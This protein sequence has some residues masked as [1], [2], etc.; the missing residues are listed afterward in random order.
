VKDLLHLVRLDQIKALTD[1]VRLRLFELFGR[2]PMTTKQAAELLG[3]PATRLYH[4][5]EI[6]AA[7]ELLELVE[8]RK[9]RGTTEKYY[10]AI[11]R[12]VIVDRKALE[13]ADGPKKG[14]KGYASLFV[15]AMEATLDEA[16]QGAG[17]IR[18][19]AQ[20]RNAVVFRHRVAADDQRAETLTARLREWMEESAQLERGDGDTE[21]GIAIAFYPIRKLKKQK[22]KKE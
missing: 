4:H 22:K 13:S 12:E 2:R 21:Y 3:Q 20:G 7:A 9:K 15:G 19:L 1:P 10:S 14:A 5:V 6:L 17:L 16:T 11:A 18:P 8:T